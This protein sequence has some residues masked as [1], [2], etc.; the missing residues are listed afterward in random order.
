MPEIERE[1]GER[2][3]EFPDWGAGTSGRGCAYGCF[4]K[5]KAEPAVKKKIEFQFIL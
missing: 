4:G 1:H 2:S 3:G 5:K